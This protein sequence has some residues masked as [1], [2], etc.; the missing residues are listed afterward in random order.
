M[1]E[2][3]PCRNSMQKT[4]S[5]LSFFLLL[6]TL[7]QVS[8]P[9]DH[10]CRTAVEHRR[11]L[12][13]QRFVVYLQRLATVRAS[14]TNKCCFQNQQRECFHAFWGPS[15]LWIAPESAFLQK[16]FK[17][18]RASLRGLG[19]GPQPVQRSSPLLRRRC[20]GASCRARAA[21]AGS[22]AAVQRRAPWCSAEW[23]FCTAGG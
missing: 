1:A 15:S 9:G 4:F 22:D 23:E 2:G 16:R 17:E 3:I 13:Y 8:R 5:G 19:H 6:A 18:T 20:R 14:K 10:G 7:R 11:I 12:R 21:L